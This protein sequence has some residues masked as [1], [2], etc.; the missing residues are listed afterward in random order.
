VHALGDMA[1]LHQVVEIKFNDI[2]NEG[3]DG[4]S[5]VEPRVQMF[6]EDLIE[7]IVNVGGH[8]RIPSVIFSVI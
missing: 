3:F 8:I 5:V 7:R 6:F 4:L 2:A 1:G